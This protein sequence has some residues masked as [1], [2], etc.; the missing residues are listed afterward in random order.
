MSVY[1][2]IYTA[3]PFCGYENIPAGRST[4]EQVDGDLVE[5]TPEAIAI[6]RGDI[7]RVDI[8]AAMRAKELKDKHVPHIGVIGHTN[9]HVKRQ[10]AQTTLRDSIALWAGVQRH[11]GR[12]DR[13]SYK[14]FYFKFGVDV[15]SAQALGERDA[16]ILTERVNKEI[17]V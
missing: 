16:Q 7:D 4:P 13:E 15:M 3:C 17:S 10:E 5:L 11:N 6:L 14:L 12:P 8:P 2:R 9:A 1:E